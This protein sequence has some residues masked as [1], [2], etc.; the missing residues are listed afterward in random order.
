MRPQAV[1]LF[2]LAAA[3][4]A[5][6]EKAWHGCHAAGLEARALGSSADLVR[7]CRDSSAQWTVEKQLGKMRQ[8]EAD[9]RRSYEKL[10][11][12]T[13][14]QERAEEDLEEAKTIMKYMKFVPS[15]QPGF[16]RQEKEVRSLQDR[17]EEIH[18]QVAQ[19]TSN[20]ALLVRKLQ[21]NSKCY[22]D[23][24]ALETLFKSS[25]GQWTQALAMN[26]KHPSSANYGDLWSKTRI[27]ADAAHKLSTAQEECAAQSS[28]GQG[29]EIKIFPRPE[30][31]ERDTGGTCAHMDCDASRHAVCDANQKCLCA[32]GF[33]NDKGQCLQRVD[34]LKLLAHEQ[35]VHVGV[36]RDALVLAS[37][38]AVMA[39]V[40]VAAR[41]GCGAARKVQLADSPFG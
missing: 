40:A 25:Y 4:A 20:T 37:L 10:A 14:E 3:D 24:D 21:T 38:A 5:V 11:T 17:R 16:P 27:V 26:E 41:Q 12:A 39:A 28:D 35:A 36:H 30:S 29:V 1:L 19:Q 9:V 32:P 22:Q 13:S 6:D 33:C 8:E 15:E 2:A 31:C 34:P 7:W 23:L 18:E